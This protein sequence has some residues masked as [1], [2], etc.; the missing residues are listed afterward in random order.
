MMMTVLGL[1]LVVVLVPER[2]DALLPSE[3][4]HGPVADD[5]IARRILLLRHTIYEQIY[6]L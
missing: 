6:E 2:R 4:R 1:V 5:K 3:R